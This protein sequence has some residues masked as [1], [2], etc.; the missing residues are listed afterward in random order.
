[1][2]SKEQ[3]RQEAAERQ[4]RWDALTVAERRAL[5]MA[6]PGES[7]KELARLGAAA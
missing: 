7:V 5:I 3:K 6:R 4:A 2:K 1:M